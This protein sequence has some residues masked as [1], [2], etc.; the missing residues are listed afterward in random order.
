MSFPTWDQEHTSGSQSMHIEGNM[1]CT[2]S[3]NI[4]QFNSE[5]MGNGISKNAMLVPMTYDG[6]VT[7]PIPA[8]PQVAAPAL[9][10]DLRISI[11]KALKST[12]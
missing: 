11:N 7:V 12:K 1:H 8:S 10:I 2:D 6:H 9:C 3:A 5:E 4:E